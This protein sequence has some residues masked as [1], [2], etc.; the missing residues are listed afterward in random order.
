MCRPADAFKHLHLWFQRIVLVLLVISFEKSYFAH[1]T[2][3]SIL[4]NGLNTPLR[5]CEPGC[6]SNADCQLGLI[7]RQWSE[8]KNQLY[9]NCNIM[10]EMYLQFD[11]GKINFCDRATSA[12]N[13]DRHLQ[14][15]EPPSHSFAPTISPKPSRSSKPSNTPSISPMP[16]LAKTTTQPTSSPTS[17]PV[18]QTSSP[19]YPP[20]DKDLTFPPSLSPTTS[21]TSGPSIKSSDAPANEPS[22]IFFP[23]APLTL[24]PTSNAQTLS[25][26]LRPTLWPSSATEVSHEP[27]TNSSEAPSNMEEVTPSPSESSADP[28]MKPS[29]VPPDSTSP[30]LRR[31]STPSLNISPSPSSQPSTVHLTSEIPSSSPSKTTAFPSSQPSPFASYAPSP[32]PTTGNPT[33]SPTLRPTFRPTKLP[34]SK[35]SFAPSDTFPPVTKYPREEEPLSGHL[36]PTNSPTDRPSPT[37]SPTKATPTPTENAQTMEPET[38]SSSTQPIDHNGSTATPKTS[39]PS[40][41]PIDASSSPAPSPTTFG[42]V[43]GVLDNRNTATNGGSGTVEGNPKSSIMIGFSIALG[44]AALLLLSLFAFVQLKRSTKGA[45]GANAVSSP[46][47]LRYPV[48]DGGGTGST[49]GGG[50][51]FSSSPQR[52]GAILDPENADMGSSVV[53]DMMNH[54]LDEMFQDTSNILA[55]FYQSPEGVGTEVKMS[56][57]DDGAESKYSKDSYGY[58][59]TDSYGYSPTNNTRRS[60]STPNRSLRPPPQMLGL[61][62]ASVCSD[63]LYT[64]Y[65]ADYYPDPP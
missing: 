29:E 9:S 59:T 2:E 27:S 31:T 3:V 42:S 48:G 53:S 39:V 63:D 33:Q 1:A 6:R 13:N 49:R 4:T 65:T 28:T 25:P 36:L 23:N 22:G 51:G 40:P 16:T 5:E 45:H 44:C 52:K 11:N 46:R 32:S 47:R 37:V 21:W 8:H 38:T 20:S 30:S 12:R 17:P 50:R 61:E 18:A 43:S 57:V 60:R 54:S 19:S 15:S 62:D 41:F 7:C 55:S 56:I 35:P 26:T 34:T 14:I 64:K 24:T 10:E 58:S